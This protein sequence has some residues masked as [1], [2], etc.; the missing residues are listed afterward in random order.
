MKN[1]T[2]GELT[3]AEAG[4]DRS[5]R[6][7]SQVGIQS[8]L[9]RSAKKY[10]FGK[11]IALPFGRLFSSGR[12]SPSYYDFQVEGVGTKTLLAELARKY[13]TIGID[14]VAMA[15]NDVIR[16]GSTPLLVSDA[17]HIAR[18]D[19]A[20]VNSILSGIGR[21]VEQSECSLASGETGDVSEILHVPLAEES[22]PFDL[23]ASCLGIAKKEDVIKG[24]ISR[25]DHI[26]GIKSSGIHSNGLSLARRVLLKK[27]GGLYE[28]F[29]RPEKL[30][31]SVIGELLVPTR[32]Y[33]KSLK[34]LRRDGIRAKAAVHITGDG[35]GKL[36]RLLD[37]QRRSD[38]GVKLELKEKPAIF[39]LII[40]SAKRMEKPIPI[41]EMFKTFNM[42]IGFCVITSPQDSA[43]AIDSLNN[44]CEAEKIGFVSNVGRIAIDSPFHPRSIF[45]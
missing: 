19:P 38:L 41:E 17:L 35:L 5:V 36:Q 21:G 31:R 44:D 14:A 13:D 24:I 7:R 33:L 37:F 8:M 11:S 4:I 27:W 12:A 40:D 29:E 28:P 9:S 1:S 26:I 2:K 22:T 10:P 15:V 20:I 43:D 32:I 30:D 23:F 18:S 45:L 42:G 25:G 3:Y 34:R 16:S 39:E 6:Q